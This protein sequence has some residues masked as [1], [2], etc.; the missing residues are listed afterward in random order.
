MV[1]DDRSLNVATS[2]VALHTEVVDITPLFRELA[3]G[4]GAYESVYTEQV[5]EKIL[6]GAPWTN[7]RALGYTGKNGPAIWMTYVPDMAIK[8]SAIKLPCFLL[9]RHELYNRQYSSQSGSVSWA[10]GSAKASVVAMRNFWGQ[11]VLSERNKA[12]EDPLFDVGWPYAITAGFGPAIVASGLEL[13]T[14]CP[15]PNFGVPL[16]LGGPDP[17]RH[18]D[19]VLRTLW[20]GGWLATGAPSAPSAGRVAIGAWSEGGLTMRELF[21]K[22]RTKKDDDP[23]RLD[24]AA[25]YAFDP[26]EIHLLYPDV[27]KWLDV[28]KSAFFGLTMGQNMPPHAWAGQAFYKMLDAAT[29]SVQTRVIGSPS[30][31]ESLTFWVNTKK[32]PTKKPSP[33]WVATVSGPGGSAQLLDEN[34]ANIGGYGP[35]HY[36]HS[37]ARFGRPFAGSRDTFLLAFLKKTKF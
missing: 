36:R 17:K 20:A 33:H 19:S 12:S 24:L 34:A 32:Q 7:V 4:M 26:N 18:L 21:L 22:N 3:G 5:K 6:D 8:S 27:L 30:A 2:V 28:D 16:G 11:W 29:P 9:C 13:V 31:D 10:V 14:I 15:I 23:T 37:F 35:E 25:V 1:L